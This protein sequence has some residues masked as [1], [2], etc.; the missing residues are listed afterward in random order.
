[1][2]EKEGFRRTWRTRATVYIRGFETLGGRHEEERVPCC[3]EE[4]LDVDWAGRMSKVSM[5]PKQQGS[6]RRSSSLPL[7][8]DEYLLHTAAVVTQDFTFLT[9]VLGVFLTLVRHI[10]AIRLL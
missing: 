10:Q 3:V 9:Q 4:N 7:N 5:V 6:G 8:N 2:V 1:M